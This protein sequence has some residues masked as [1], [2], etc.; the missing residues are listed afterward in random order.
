M[1]LLNN[2]YFEIIKFHCL[3]IVYAFYLKP[4]CSPLEWTDPFSVTL[5]TFYLDV[6]QIVVE[7]GAL[8]GI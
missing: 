6:F 4:A 1:L 2:K 5:P 8:K 3:E 7:T